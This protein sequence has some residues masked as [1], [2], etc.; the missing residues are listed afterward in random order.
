[1][2]TMTT[3]R[4]RCSWMAVFL[5]GLCASAYAQQVTLPQVQMS[6][7]V[8]Q[9]KPESLE[10]ELSMG[11]L[12]SA[13]LIGAAKLVPDATL[14]KYINLVGRRVADQAGRKDLNWAFGVID[15]TALNAFA[16]PGGYILVTSGL[17]Q[18]L[19]SEDELAGVLG[20]EVAH[21][22]RKHH[23]RVLR[24]QQ[25]LEFGAKAVQIQGES[26][27]MVNQ[28]S[29]MVGQ[30]LARGLDQSAE[31]EADRDGMV[32]AA[33]AGYD[34]S[35]LTRVMA[36]LDSGKSDDTNLLLATHPSP[37][38][39][40]QSMATAATPE[41]EKAAVNSPAADRLRKIRTLDK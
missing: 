4:L 5:L 38:Q 27:D 1:M 21:V 3:D 13:Q 35:A 31:Y 6:G 24:K 34:S 40:A 19:E 37:A 28:L 39:R 30:I 33:R 26:G 15:S 32:Y 17:F 18:I 2:K 7:L 16:A 11:R 14:Q 12:V 8:V 20:H 10:E 29:S 41:L 9:M 23:Y 22:V 25:M 36:R